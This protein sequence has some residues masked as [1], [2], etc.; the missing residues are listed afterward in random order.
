M[1][2]IVKGLDTIFRG[3]ALEIGSSVIVN[4][5]GI[6]LGVCQS[7]TATTLMVP[8]GACAECRAPESEV[9]RDP[10]GDGGDDPIRCDDDRVPPCD[11]HTVEP[12][13][14]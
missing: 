5:E 9:I 3:K 7:C 10:L 4:L 12:D 1:T 14:D 6:Y 2:K 11:S 13:A 8:G